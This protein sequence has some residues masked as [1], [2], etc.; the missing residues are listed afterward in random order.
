MLLPLELSAACFSGEDKVLARVLLE[1]EK[2]Y[3]DF[4]GLNCRC[5]L[6]ALDKLSGHPCQREVEKQNEY[7][8]SMTVPTVGCEAGPTPVAWAKKMPCVYSCNHTVAMDRRFVDI[9]R[10]ANETCPFPAGPAVSPP[11][12][13]YK[14]PPNVLLDAPSSTYNNPP[15]HNLGTNEGRLA[16]RLRRLAGS[17]EAALTAAVLAQLSGEG[18]EWWMAMADLAVSGRAAGEA[19]ERQS[20]SVSWLQAQ[21]EPGVAEKYGAQAVQ[22][23]CRSVLERAYSVAEA[24]PLPS[25]SPERVAL[26]W[27]A[28]S[29]EDDMPRFPVN[30]PSSRFPQRRVTVTGVGPCLEGTRNVSSRFIVALSQPGSVPGQIPPGAEIFLFVHGMDSRAEEAE[31]MAEE[32]VARGRAL[33]RN[34]GLV[35]VDLP[36]SGYADKIDH[37]DISPLDAIGH[38]DQVLGFLPS[39][40]DKNVTNVPV[41]QFIENFIVRFAEQLL[42]EQPFRVIAVV[43]GS[44]GGNMALR[45]GRRRDLP[46]ISNIIGWSPASIWPSLATGGFLDRLAPRQ[47]WLSAGGDKA[48][49]EETAQDRQKFFAASFDDRTSPVSPP[50]PEMWYAKTWPCIKTAIVADRIDRQETYSRNFRLWHWRLATE[51]LIFSHQAIVGGEPLFL[52]NVKNILLACGTDDAFLFAEICPTTIQVSA[53]MVSTPGQARFFN[54]TGHSIHSERPHLFAQHWFEFLNLGP[55]D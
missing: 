53:E 39:F 31:G 17:F 18:K 40:D 54:S 55:S 38:P 45:L 43:G 47:G 3:S 23:A 20:P 7:C 14:L 12:A 24:L 50:Q 34:L 16:A 8:H 13:G 48:N 52:R 28:V 37:L 29:G 26:G 19:F 46:W 10:D 35:A 11:N 2:C 33:G 32:V 25:S 41:L 49:L 42:E 21:L 9:S 44:L 15:G 27:I 4:G 30:V 1:R 5:I 6:E 36:T 22:E 51:Q